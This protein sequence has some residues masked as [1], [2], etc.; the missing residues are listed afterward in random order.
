M[1]QDNKTKAEV[2]N[3]GSESKI[4]LL[5]FVPNTWTCQFAQFF[6]QEVEII[7]E[8]SW[9]S[10]RVEETHGSTFTFRPLDFPPLD[11]CEVMALRS[12]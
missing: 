10:S 12:N 5:Y 6:H 3:P 8:I 7:N 2:E 4:P 1:N 11:K 9:L